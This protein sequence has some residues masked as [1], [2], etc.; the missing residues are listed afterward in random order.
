LMYAM[1]FY[2]ANPRHKTVIDIF[3]HEFS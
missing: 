3:L 1:F 2:L